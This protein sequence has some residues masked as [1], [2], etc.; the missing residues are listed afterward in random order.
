MLTGCTV[1]GNI[2]FGGVAG[3]DGSLLLGCDLLEN[4][5]VPGFGGVNDLSG[6]AG[7][8]VILDST[9]SANAADAGGLYFARGGGASQSTLV[10]CDVALNQVGSSPDSDGGGVYHCDVRHSSL[11]DNLASGAGGGAAGGTLFRCLVYDNRAEAGGGAADAD[12][13]HCTL[14]GN[15]AALGDGLWVGPGVQVALTNAILYGNGNEEIATDPGAGL[16]VSFSDVLGGWPGPGNIAA[17]P[18][19]VAPGAHDY[20]LQFNSPCTDKGDPTFPPDPDGSRTD[21]G[22]LRGRTNVLENVSA[23]GGLSSKP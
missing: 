8:S 17:D 23:R 12:I 10:D 13:D 4:L 7:R 1:R 14:E 16:S 11:F 18:L 6:G 22:A 21:M 9:L 19:F 5:A 3:V 15:T 20:H 2:A